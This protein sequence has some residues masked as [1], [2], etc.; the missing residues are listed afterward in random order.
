MSRPFK[1]RRVRHFICRDIPFLPLISWHSFGLNSCA[2]R[3]AAALLH[4]SSFTSF[5]M[6]ALRV[7]APPERFQ[8]LATPAQEILPVPPKKHAC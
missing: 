4:A 1:E 6:R 2:R 5:R 8:P 7:S 3:T